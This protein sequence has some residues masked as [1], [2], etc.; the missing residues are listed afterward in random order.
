MSGGVVAV[1]QARTGSTRLPGKV[2]APIAGRPLV[3]W[4]LGAL[5]AVAGLDTVVLAIP[6]ETSDDA[7]AALG[8]S[9]GPVF[10]GSA[11]DVLDRVWRAALPYGPAFVVRATA[12]NPFPDPDLVAAEVEHCRGGRLDYVRSTG[13]PLGIGVEVVRWAALDQAAH[14]ARSPAEREHVMPYLYATPG[15][16]RTGEVARPGGPGPHDRFTVDTD[17]DLALARAVADRAGH[18]P[19]IRLAELEAIVAAEPSLAALNGGVRQTAWT[20]VEG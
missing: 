6:D 14:K 12:D 2:L 3:E 13:Y 11:H 8:A 5:R 18:P 16:F 7:L 10:R 17:G 20:E 19:P 9:L 1:V 4:T 15:R